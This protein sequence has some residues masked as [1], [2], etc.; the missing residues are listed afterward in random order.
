MADTFQIA[1]LNTNLTGPL[2]PADIDGLGSRAL[3][4]PA[5]TATGPTFA[6]TLM[7]SGAELA[8]TIQ[9]AEKVS[10]DGING[11]ASA[12][13]V[14]SSIMEAQQQLKMATAVRDKIVQSFLEISR[15][16]I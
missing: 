13:E 8:E 16:Q 6:E 15:M 3:G 2:G 10:V 1:A 12:Y 7:N 14:A 5:Q 11:K 9:K 4:T